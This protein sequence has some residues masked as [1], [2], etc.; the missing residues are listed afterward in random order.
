MSSE[1][2]PP[3]FHKTT[4]NY[5]LWRKK[6]KLWQH[7]SSVDVCKQGGLL[8]LQLDDET[9]DT[10]LELMTIEDI[11]KEDGTEK[12]LKHLDSMFKKDEYSM[13]VE[14][15]EDLKCYKR[16]TGV[17]IIQYCTEFQKRFSKVKASGT[18]LSEH[19][20]TN[21]LLKSANLSERETRLVRATIPKMDYKNMI[22]H[23]KKVF[24]SGVHSDSLEKDTFY[25]DS[26]SRGDDLKYRVSKDGNK[27]NYHNPLDIYG[28]YTRCRV[29]ESFLHLENNCPDKIQSKR[30]TTPN[31]CMAEF[32]DYSDSGESWLTSDLNNYAIDDSEEICT[33][34]QDDVS[35]LSIDTDTSYKS[36]I[37]MG[38]SET[39]FKENCVEGKVQ[40]AVSKKGDSSLEL[41]EHTDTN[42]YTAGLSEYAINPGNAGCKFID[43]SQS[44]NF[45]ETSENLKSAEDSGRHHI[46]TTEQ[47]SGFKDKDDVL[48]NNR[49]LFPCVKCQVG[50]ISN[51]YDLAQQNQCSKMRS[52]QLPETV[53]CCCNQSESEESKLKGMYNIGIPLDLNHISRIEKDKSNSWKRRRKRTR[54]K[55]QQG[56]IWK[57]NWKKNRVN[58]RNDVLISKNRGLRNLKRKEKKRM[59]Y[60]KIWNHRKKEKRN[61]ISRIR[62]DKRVWKSSQGRLKYEKR[63][64]RYLYSGM[65]YQWK[66]KKRKERVRYRSPEVNLLA[67]LYILFSVIVMHAY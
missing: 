28:N 18:H 2:I 45:Y 35:V 61:R 58:K 52:N 37:S 64:A 50:E 16:P 24:D 5:T 62:M 31:T 44:E 32:I 54:Y 59:I 47:Q 57:E 38:N 49:E 23:L 17:P 25:S 7:I 63:E 55:R 26:R 15:Y 21:K 66:Q 13:A 6:F 48:L 4:D 42:S 46:P 39:I 29:C 30:S 56:R 19:V 36:L 10:I 65:K 67:A 8:T 14:L 34:A 51:D 20:V 43:L 27:L 11:K 53:Y 40:T 22:N 1:K 60:E 33:I 12:L 41:Q 9:Q 3:H